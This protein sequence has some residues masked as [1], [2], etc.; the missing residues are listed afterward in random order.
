MHET[1]ASARN[2]EVDGESL[3][4]AGV[5]KTIRLF[6]FAN[7]TDERLRP[8]EPRYPVNDLNVRS[9]L[10][11]GCFNAYLQHRLAVA[12]SEGGVTL[13]DTAANTELMQFEEHVNRVWSV[14]C[15]PHDPALML[16]ASMDKT[17]RLWSSS[18]ESS[19][20][21]VV[22]S[23]QVRAARHLPLSRSVMCLPVSPMAP[24]T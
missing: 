16:S 23:H 4:G 6:R 19:V 13:V 3:G 1:E 22:E 18:Q 15:S 8:S 11:S 17:V 7:M 24:G 20:G 14:D 10:T 21:M 5:N 2:T 12:D 9:K